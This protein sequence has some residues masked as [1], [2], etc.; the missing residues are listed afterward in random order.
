LTKLWLNE[1]ST[2][3]LRHGVDVQDESE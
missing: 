1:V 2:V 3:F